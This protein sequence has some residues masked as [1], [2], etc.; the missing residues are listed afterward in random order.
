MKAVS[1]F[2]KNPSRHAADYEMLTNERFLRGAF[3]EGDKF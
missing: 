2:E 1:L 3:F